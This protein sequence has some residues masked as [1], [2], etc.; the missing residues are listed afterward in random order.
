MLTKEELSKI[1]RY[2]PDT[3]VCYYTDS[4]VATKNNL[5]AGEPNGIPFEVDHIIP[6]NGKN[7]CGFHM[8]ENLHVIT[9]TDNRTK[10]NK[11]K[12]VA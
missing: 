5:K 2:E 7:V 1:I 11:L 9:K 10:S 12:G 6:L 8:V 3:G 4:Y